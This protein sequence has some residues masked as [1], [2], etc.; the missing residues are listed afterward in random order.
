MNSSPTH[1]LLNTGRS[2]KRFH[3]DVGQEGSVD[4]QNLQPERAL[5]AAR[6]HALVRA[7]GTVFVS[8]TLPALRDAHVGPGTLERLR[9]AGLGL[10]H[11][12]RSS[13][14]TQLSVF[15]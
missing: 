15:L 1:V 7:V 2:E 5:T 14:Q 8:V 9:A 6:F 12:N 11:R 10:C 3:D 13:L 4:E